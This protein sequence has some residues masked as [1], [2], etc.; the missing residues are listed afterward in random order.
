VLYTAPSGKRTA[1][2]F[3]FV[4]C[5]TGKTALAVTLVGEGAGVLVH[6]STLTLAPGVTAPVTAHVPAALLNA[7]ASASV[8]VRNATATLAM[9]VLVPSTFPASSSSSSSSSSSETM[10]PAGSSTPT[11]Y[12]AG[13]QAALV[14]CGLLLAGGVGLYCRRRYR[15]SLLQQREEQLHPHGSVEQQQLLGP[16]QGGGFDLV[17]PPSRSPT[18]PGGAGAL[19]LGGLRKPSRRGE[20]PQAVGLVLG[21]GTVV[22]TPQEAVLGGAQARQSQ[23]A[24]HSRG[25]A[26]GDPPA[27]GGAGHAAPN[28]DGWGDG[29]DDGGWDL[30]DSSLLGSDNEGHPAEDASRPRALPPPLPAKPVLQLKQ[31]AQQPATTAQPHRPAAAAQP[32]AGSDSDWDA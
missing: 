26:R 12:D 2:R 15:N 21:A 10:S 16:S 20:S 30:S 4:V 23:H 5:N 8:R 3:I 32:P 27:G 29:G 14:I 11:S 17:G 9:V 24:R 18:L 22:A 6:P 7:S 13:S 28:W 25:P 19:Q 31:P 1:G